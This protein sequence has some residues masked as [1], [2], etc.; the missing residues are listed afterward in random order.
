MKKRIYEIIEVGEEYDPLSKIYDGIMLLVIILSIIPMTMRNPGE[1]WDIVDKCCAGVFIVDYILRLWTADLKLEGEKHPY[2][3][4]PFTPMAVI[5]LV[6]ILPS[7]VRLHRVLIAL[8]LFR[9]IRVIKVFKAFRVFKTFRYSKN[10]SLV[11]KV[12]KD[13]RDSLV[14]VIM[15][16]IA[17]I[18]VCAL[19]VYNVEPRT[20][21]NFFNALYWATISLAT[22]GY[23]DITPVTAIGRLMTMISSIL[24]VAVI[25]LPSGIITAGFMEE[26]EKSRKKEDADAD[27]EDK[28]VGTG[29]E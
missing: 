24:G 28:G 12:I 4:Y 23:G 22:V 21:T 19:I 14:T 9:V 8:R 18:F 16:V 5:D 6:S 25:A 15:V 17:Y 27:D 10:M 7:L 11:T 29:F 26:L 2:L 3:M 1:I 20:F 13:S